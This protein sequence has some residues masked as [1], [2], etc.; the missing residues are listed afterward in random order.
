MTKPKCRSAIGCLVTRVSISL[1]SE[2]LSR[3]L[4]LAQATEKLIVCLA[5]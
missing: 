1:S 4:S 5:R 3:Y 2:V